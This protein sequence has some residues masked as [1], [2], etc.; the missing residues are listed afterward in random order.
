MG[1]LN[2]VLR[3]EEKKGARPF[4]R[5]EANIFST[6]IVDMNLHDLGFN[7]YPFT[8]SSKR[9]DNSRVEERLDRALSNEKWNDLFP[10]STIHHLITRGS[11]HGPII[12]KTNPDW[13]DRAYTFKYFGGWMEH[14]DYKG[15]IRDSWKQSQQG[16]CRGA[17]ETRLQQSSSETMRKKAATNAYNWE[18]ELG[19]RMEFET[20]SGQLIKLI[21]SLHAEKVGERFTINNDGK[22][23]FE[24]GT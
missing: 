4:N 14:P 11:D 13:K 6:I 19:S 7:G 3:K 10:K 22:E 2:V 20:H 24:V 12:F 16:T 5:E 9:E 15:V 1:D 23:V 8:W 17:K 18:A 21:R